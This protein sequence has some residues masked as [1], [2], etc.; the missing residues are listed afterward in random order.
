MPDEDLLKAAIIRI[1]AGK[2][3]ISN[4]SVKGASESDAIADKK[5]ICIAVATMK[6]LDDGGVLKKRT[7]GERSTAMEK[8]VSARR[9]K[10][11]NKTRLVWGDRVNCKLE[12]VDARATSAEHAFEVD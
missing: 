3:T 10:D 7:E 8:S 2:D 4:A 6:N 11:I 5:T 1:M 9:V 12:E